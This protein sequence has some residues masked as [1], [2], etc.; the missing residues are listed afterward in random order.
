MENSVIEN[1][2]LA[3]HAF[4]SIRKYGSAPTTSHPLGVY[5]MKNGGRDME[6]Q[7]ETLVVLEEGIEFDESL[8]CCLAAIAPII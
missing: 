1:P 2:W 4:V 5:H 7:N 6:L 8:T 3:G